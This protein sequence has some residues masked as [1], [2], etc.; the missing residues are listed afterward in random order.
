MYNTSNSAIS[1]ESKTAIG[2]ALA[3]GW[4]RDTRPIDRGAPDRQGRARSTGRFDDGW[5]TTHQYE[6]ASNLC[7]VCRVPG[8]AVDECRPI[9]KPTQLLPNVAANNMQSHVT[10]D[11]WQ[12]IP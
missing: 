3:Y 5:L 6:C 12:Q 7:D 11:M 9:T 8:V 1:N 2:D 4:E 10:T